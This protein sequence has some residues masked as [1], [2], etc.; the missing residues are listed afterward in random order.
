MEFYVKPIVKYFARHFKSIT[1]GLCECFCL[2][3]WQFCRWKI[4]KNKLYP[5]PK[6]KWS[7]CGCYLHW[8]Y[9]FQLPVLRRKNLRAILNLSM[10]YVYMY[11]I[12]STYNYL[13]FV[14]V[15]LYMDW[16]DC[17][18]IKEKIEKKKKMKMIIEN[19]I[20]YLKYTR[21]YTKKLVYMYRETGARSASTHCS[22]G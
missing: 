9:C 10:R 2:C 22:W 6:G 4:L 18:N 12:I 8:F 11:Y 13:Y 16:N 21:I 1:F 5:T 7:V 19:W 15:Y 17:R 20:K 3:R 14:F